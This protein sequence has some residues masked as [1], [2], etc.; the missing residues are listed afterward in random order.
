MLPPVLWSGVRPRRV[1]WRVPS[2]FAA[3]HTQPRHTTLPSRTA[4]LLARVR[5]NHTRPAPGACHSS[6]PYLPL[7]RVVHLNHTHP[8]PLHPKLRCPAHGRYDLPLAWM[9]PQSGW[10]VAAGTKN[11]KKKKKKKFRNFEFYSTASKAASVCVWANGGDV[12]L[13]ARARACKRVCLCGRVVVWS[14]GRA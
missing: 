11:N 4:Q 12:R 3:N 13:C 5:L 2:A 6:K 14:C 10:R 8:A 9:N 1:S 7:A